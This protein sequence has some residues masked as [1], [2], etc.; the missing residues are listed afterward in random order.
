[1]RRDWYRDAAVWAWIAVVLLGL[2]PL[3]HAIAG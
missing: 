1:M 2:V 3:A